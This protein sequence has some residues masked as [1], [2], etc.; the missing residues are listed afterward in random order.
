M[1]MSSEPIFTRLFGRSPIEPLQQHMITCERSVESLATFFEAV[2]ENDWDAAASAAARISAEEKEADNIKREIRLH[3]PR[4]LFL[5][6]ARTDLL[7]LLHSQDKIA[8]RS[9]DVAG[10]VIGRKMTFPATI[11]GEMSNF[12]AASVSAVQLARS[13]MDE[14]N[15]LVVSGFSGQEIEV[16]EKILVDLQAA[17][18]HSDEVQVTLRQ[19]LLEQEATLNPVDVFFMYKIIDLVGDIADYAQSVGNRMM[20]LIAR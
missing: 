1:E 14:L 19:A 17:E 6:V 10:L 13:A 8:N 3:L 18:S 20:Y 9:E 7:E 12:V 11:A 5:P 2:L 15:D 16:V 4:S